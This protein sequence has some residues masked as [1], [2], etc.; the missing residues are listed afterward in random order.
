MTR[1]WGISCGG[2]GTFHVEVT[3]SAPFTFV[4]RSVQEVNSQVAQA[5]SE[6]K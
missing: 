5:E 4:S 6:C 2:T 3:S 1:N